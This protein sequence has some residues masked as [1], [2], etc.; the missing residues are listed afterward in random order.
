MHDL[1]NDYE[2]GGERLIS[3]FENVCK[4]ELEICQGRTSESK[5]KLAAL[6]KGAEEEI[7]RELKEIKRRPVKEYEKSWQEHRRAQKARL[8]AA[9]GD[10]GE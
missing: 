9:L 10:A 6:Y 3:K 2:R 7:V 4:E 1:V 8:E 5:R